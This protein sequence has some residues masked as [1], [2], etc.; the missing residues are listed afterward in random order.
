MFVRLLAVLISHALCCF[1]DLV[2]CRSLVKFVVQ[3]G[4]FEER[5]NQAL[6]S[7][8]E[9]T[10]RERPE[11]RLSTPVL[12]CKEPAIERLCDRAHHQRSRAS[13]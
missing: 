1:S 5:R 10:A 2:Y 9:C 12:E 4:G 13:T 7:A 3:K 8:I 11:T 6:G